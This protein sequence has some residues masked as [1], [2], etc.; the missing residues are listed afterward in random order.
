MALIA[1]SRLA[2]SL[3]LRSPAL[4]STCGEPV[5]GT[6]QVWGQ[7]MEV[8]DRSLLC[9]MGMQDPKVEH[10]LQPCS[11][12]RFDLHSVYT[13]SRALHDAHLALNSSIPPSS[14]V[15]IFGSLPPCP[16]AFL[17]TCLKG[18]GYDSAHPKAGQM[19]H[20]L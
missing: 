16:L 9:P 13:A 11:W 6:Q 15:R 17:H 4:L 3:T 1:L 5:G 19:I 8:M 14:K 18:P 7:N 10:T 20:I 12:S 2:G